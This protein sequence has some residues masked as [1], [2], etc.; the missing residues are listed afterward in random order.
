MSTTETI[1][2]ETTALRAP[3]DGAKILIAVPCLDH[4][5]AEFTQSL[6]NLRKTSGTSYAMNINCLIY[7]SRNMFAAHAIEKGYDRILW[8]DSDMCLE[9][10]A[11]IK[12]NADM[13]QGREFV[14]G[15]Y[16]RRSLPTAPVVYKSMRYE[17]IE[18]GMLS[19][20]EPYWDYPRN[21]I[22][23]IQGAGFGCVMTSV[24]LLKRVWDRFGP[25]FDPMTQISE[26]L[27]FCWRVTQLGVKMYCD[28]GV[29]V[30]HIGTLI[31]DEQLYQQQQGISATHC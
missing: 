7:R 2:K 29:R 13:E 18:G 19:D 11:L 27:A 30:G 24:D 12:L 10:D 31:Y 8:L 16:F 14:C 20:N 17:T 3:H 26:D 23:Q 4:V 21:S 6:L 22:F 9:Q 15:M 28:S 1:R 5:H 25:P